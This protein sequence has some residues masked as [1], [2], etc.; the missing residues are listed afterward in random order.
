[1]LKAGRLRRLGNLCRMQ[2]QDHCRKITLD[3][4]EGCRRVNRPAIRWLAGFSGRT[5]VGSGVVN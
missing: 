3:K 5:Q 2:E 1:M 4:P